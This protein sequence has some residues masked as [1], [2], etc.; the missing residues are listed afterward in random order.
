MSDMTLWNNLN[1]N[2]HAGMQDFL[3]YNS[4]SHT[5][6]AMALE[7]RNKGI[8]SFHIGD[9]G[10]IQDWLSTHAQ[11]HQNEF[12]VIGLVGLPDLEDVDFKVAE[13][14]AD[15]MVLHSAVHV[16]VNTALGIVP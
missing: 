14:L 8:P 16:A 3:L 11:T 9:I 13:Q 1:P 5:Q 2:D 15:W 6:V 4:L 7:L 10:N 12:S